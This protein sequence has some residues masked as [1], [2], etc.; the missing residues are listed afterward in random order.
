MK[1]KAFGVDLNLVQQG[2]DERRGYKGL[3][4]SIPVKP[5]NNRNLIPIFERAWGMNY[6][7]VKKERMGWQVFWIDRKKLKQLT[8]GLRVTQIRY[9]SVKSKQISILLENKYKKY[10]VEVR[11]SKAG[12]YPNDTKFR[13]RPG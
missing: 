6:F 8:N 10:I 3:R 9:P 2:F 12:E 11:N 5:F 13:V 4:D 1:R 7:Y